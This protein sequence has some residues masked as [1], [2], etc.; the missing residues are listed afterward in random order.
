VNVQHLFNSGGKWIAFRQ[1][2]QVFDERCNWIG[3]LP[4][5]NH[6]VA[7]QEGE[8]L[9]TI[10]DGNRFYYFVDRPRRSHPGHPTQPTYP[11]HQERPV[12]AVRVV[13]PPG[14]IDVV[15]LKRSRD[16]GFGSSAQDVETA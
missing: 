12:G 1:Q 11:V 16:Q 2:Q 10:V 15:S 14:A 6:E 8:Y 7:T 3:W 13:L 5:G 4:W 9:G